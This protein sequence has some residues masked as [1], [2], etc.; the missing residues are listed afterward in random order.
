MLAVRFDISWSVVRA[1]S[2]IVALVARAQLAT[3]ADTAA[4]QKQSTARERALRGDARE[5]DSADLPFR[6]QFETCF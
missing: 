2:L 6:E 1:D 5:P 4:K 3:A